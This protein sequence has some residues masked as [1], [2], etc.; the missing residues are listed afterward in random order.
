MRTKAQVDGAGHEVGPSVL[1]L[2]VVDDHGVSLPDGGEARTFIQV[3]LHL[4]EL[5]DERTG[6]DKGCVG[7]VTLGHADPTW[8]S[9]RQLFCRLDDPVEHGRVPSPPHHTDVV[10]SRAIRF[11]GGQFTASPGVLAVG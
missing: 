7:V 8:G 9:W 5:E 3:V 4:V 1:A 2:R 11:S 10:P 6:A